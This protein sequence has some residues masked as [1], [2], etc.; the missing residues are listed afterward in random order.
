M[1][2]LRQVIVCVG[3]FSLVGPSP[4]RTQPASRP[5]VKEVVVVFKTHFDI[6][7]TDTI[8]AVLERY[9]TTMIDTALDVVDQAQGMPAGQR[10][11]WTLPGWPMGR[12]LGPDERFFRDR[13]LKPGDSSGRSR[14]LWPAQ[15]P[16][17]R[18]RILKA[19]RDGRFVW[20]ALPFTTHTE[21]LE[22]EDLVRGTGY[23]SA[24]SRCLDL[25]LPRDAK[26]TD[27]PSHVWSLAT[28]L[29]R[30]GVEFL[31]VGVNGASTAPQ[32]PPVFWWEG[33]DGSRLLTM[34]SAS[35]GTGLL[36]PEDWPYPVWLALIHTGDNKGPP[37][38]EDLRKLLAEAADKL[39]GVTV[40]LGR[41]SDFADALRR[42]N[43]SLPVIRMDMPDT[44]IHGLMA[45]PIASG[46]AR[47]LRPQI[48]GVQAMDA[49]LGLWGHKSA[50]SLAEDV[51][52]AYEQS[53]LYGEHTWGISYRCFTPRLYGPAWEE[54]RAAGKY[55]ACEKTWADHCAYVENLESLLTPMIKATGARMAESVAVEGP[56]VVVF[57]P[58]PW[59][60]DE[61]VTVEARPAL[62]AGLVDAKTGE[63]VVGGSADGQFRFIARNLPPMGYRTYKPG[64]PG[65]AKG[66]LKA[67]EATATLENDRLRV[68][69]DVQRGVISSLVDK[70][71]G[72]EFVDSKAEYGLGQYLYERF[73]AD[74]AT[75]FYAAYCA[76]LKRP[77]SPWIEEDFG[78]SGLPPASEVPY[79]AASPGGFDVRFNATEV[80]ASSVLTSPAGPRVPHE[81][82][83][84]VTIYRGM[85]FVDLNWSVANKK[86]EPW[87]E[88][89]WLCLPFKVD[90]PQFALGRLGCVVNPARDLARFS[91]HHVFCLNTGLTI[92]GPNGGGVGLCPIDSPLVSL[93][94]P[95]LW[96]FSDRFVPARPIAFV[97]LFN[98]Q[99]ST[100]FA[101]WIEGSWSSRVRLW[102]VLGEGL[103]ADLMTPAW[104][105]RLTSPAFA[106]DAA[107]GPMP[108]A[109]AGLDFS[110]SG[111]IVTA[112]GENPDGQGI[113]LRLW[114]QA[115]S[116]EPCRVRFPETAIPN[117]AQPVDLRGRPIGDSLTV[118]DGS[119]LVPMTRFAPTSLVLDMPTGQP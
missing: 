51:S 6:G 49:L 30:A 89:G 76:H 11:V 56:R 38:P 54:A 31:H 93:D 21:S 50:R 113:L 61:V 80:Y 13:A 15:S 100:N 84:T 112:F 118:E 17:R 1:G 16:D 81:V 10:F 66:M 91:N 69:L 12:I 67:D 78:K 9:R 99:W 119:C 98:N 41:L 111:L 116:N 7:Y 36:P 3:M 96:R 24:L 2:L 92:T 115:G 94:R 20:H 53:L 4:A 104:E 65:S 117:R 46:K 63:S 88:A 86:A 27:V 62:Q 18:E 74:R 45:S 108:P 37:A 35:Y 32:V 102:P 23:S 29:S 57:N 105:A 110:R 48:A 19:I 114:E 85:S 71:T 25:P 60:R 33:P 5:A 22:L 82:S 107:A 68:R 79:V 39:P 42:A 73:D 26:M 70:R 103:T 87:P 58:L 109:H 72:R 52:L 59:R 77:F 47:R 97:N 55:A 83:L 14:V 101:Q 43:P 28:I 90:Q 95:G 64:V 34:V 75:T 44:W 8:D 106:T 40:R